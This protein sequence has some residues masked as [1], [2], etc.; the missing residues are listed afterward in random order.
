MADIKKLGVQLFTVRDYMGNEASMK[1]TFARLKSMGYDEVQTAGCPVPYDV[2]GN[3]CADAGLEIV[4]THDNL[5]MMFDEPEKAMECHDLLHTKIM[6][7]GG[8]GFADVAALDD[9]CVKVNRLCSV[10]GPRGFKFS[11]HNHSSEFCKLEDGKTILAHLADS[12]D[13]KYATF[14]LDTYW[15]QHGGGDVREWIK[16]LAG[17]IEIIHLK[18][19]AMTPGGAVMT[20]IGNGNLYWEGI[21]EE[22]NNSGVNHFVV[23]HDVNWTDDDPFK[24]LEISADYLRKNF[25]A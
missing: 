14:C 1:E 24:S 25:L 19:M 7:I 23:E 18:D 4:G 9:F 11:Y 6:G 22:A 13:A 20:E 10:I 16:K 8:Y 12:L 17:R 5:S 3:L 21:I 2:F 15:V